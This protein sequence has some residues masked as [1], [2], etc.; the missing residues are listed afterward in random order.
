MGKTGGGPF[1]PFCSAI[2]VRRELATN[3]FGERGMEL[4]L[5]PKEHEPL[6]ELLRHDLERLRCD[7]ARSHRA[8]FRS[9]L[10]VKEDL[11]E[12]LLA[13]LCSLVTPG[14]HSLKA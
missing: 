4:E 11:M 10:K 1:A 12:E 14:P 5:F 8:T 13:K 6:I 7:S 2:V 3:G 9:E